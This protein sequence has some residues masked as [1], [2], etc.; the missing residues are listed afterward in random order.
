MKKNVWKFLSPFALLSMMLTSC[1]NGQQSTT[2]P[3]ASEQTGYQIEAQDN[4]GGSAFY[5]IFV[6]SFSDSNGD[7]V[8]DLK[9][10]EQ[11]LDYLDDLGVSYLW[12]TPIH[13]SNTYH[14]YNVDDYYD[15]DPSFG[16]LA[17]FDSLIAKAKEKGIGIIL[18]MVF[19]H[20]GVTSKWFEEFRKAIVSKDPSNPYY[21][22]Y[23]VSRNPGS[24]YTLIQS[25]GCY[26]ETNFDS[27]MPELNWDSEHVRTELKNIQDFWLDHGVAGFRYDAVKYYYCSNNNG[28]IVGDD[29]KNLEAMTYLANCAKA[30]KEDVYLVGENWVEDISNIAYLTQSGMNIFNF[31]TCGL[32]AAGSAGKMVTKGGE[33]QFSSTVA[34]HQAILKEKGADLCYFVSNHDMDRWGAYRKGLKLATEARKCMASAYLLTPGTPYM[35]YGE[36]I[37]MLGSRGSNEMTDAMRR[38]AMVWGEGDTHLCNQPERYAVKEQTEDSVKA[39]LEDP[40]SVLNHYRKVLS[41]RNKYKDLFRKGTF[42]AL[43]VG[44]ARATGFKITLNN[45][46]YYLVHNT[47]SAQESIELPKEASIIEKIDTNQVAP[48]LSGKTLTLGAYSSALLQ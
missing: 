10:I 43:N 39:A 44:S 5:E 45:E 12:L 21:N 36:E 6:G 33:G 15:I 27:S 30:K 18:D 14:K 13:P 29:E 41:I 34:S 1:G 28:N 48:S 26:V 7:G 4:R 19:N 47:N 32:T 46:T 11:K 8:G 40:W 42:E 20:T 31:P 9:G 38:Q 35:Y 16:T 3:A 25:V 37:S 17:D 23:S 22:D 2:E 24:G